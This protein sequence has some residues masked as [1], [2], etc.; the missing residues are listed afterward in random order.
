MLTIGVAVVA[1]I[2]TALVPTRTLAG[3]IL[4]GVVATVAI[5]FAARWSTPAYFALFLPALVMLPSLAFGSHQ[6][7]APQPEPSA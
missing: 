2:A 7:P 5:M 1:L 3:A 6:D 4:C